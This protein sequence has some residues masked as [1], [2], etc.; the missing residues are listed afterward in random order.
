MAITYVKDHVTGETYTVSITLQEGSLSDPI[1][2][3]VFYINYSV[4]TY[5][6]PK[7]FPDFVLL[8]I[9]PDETLTEAIQN[10]LAAH[11]P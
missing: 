6:Q 2:D 3:P 11:L 4:E 7:Y 8:D 9:A 10:A 5:T 1:G